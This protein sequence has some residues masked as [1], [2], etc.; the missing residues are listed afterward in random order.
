MEVVAFDPGDRE[1]LR[2]WVALVNAARRADSPW[3]HAL[4]EHE[5][6][7]ELRYGW[8]MEPADP[9]LAVHDG[10]PV[11]SAV[12][13]TNTW[14]N[15]HLVWVRFDV[16]PDHR[17][18]GHG[19]RVLAALLDRAVAEGR[20]SVGT[21][22]WDNPGALAFAERHGLPCRSREVNRRQ[23][24]AEV[25]RAALD[26]MHRDAAAHAAAYEV[27]RLEGPVPE[28][29]LEAYAVMVAA[30]NDAPL[31]DLEADD[32]VY[33]P[34]RI[35]AYEQ[36]QALRGLRVRRLYARHRET[37]DLAGET[38]VVVD[39]ERPHLAHQHDTSVVRAHRGHRLGLLLKLEM[40]R[41]LEEVEPQV[42]TVDTWNAES[43]D[44]MVA[45]NE[46][47]G[48]R[49]LGRALAYQRDL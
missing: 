32:E 25:D 27:V 26:A 47:L 30:I 39:T 5:A 13:E 35:R 42:R 31:D 40:L 9:Y 38:V 37:G 1:A 3:M 45:V 29:L 36:A 48:Y 49:V 34:A 33:T 24:L 19:S 15:Q 43:N 6:A 10:V 17:R 8:D 41:W 23:H 2:T 16:H 12:Y 4:T 46:A 22:S 28:P 7:G 21:D 44:H 14:D 11:A 20:T 18:R